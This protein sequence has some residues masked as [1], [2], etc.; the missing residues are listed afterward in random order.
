MFNAAESFS[1]VKFPGIL[2]APPAIAPTVI[3]LT[4]LD[5]A[6]EPNEIPAIGISTVYELFRSIKLGSFYRRTIN[7]KKYIKSYII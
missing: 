2:F 4:P 7:Y 5:I 6:T 3:I 1:N